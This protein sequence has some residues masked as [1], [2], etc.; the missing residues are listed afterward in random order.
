MATLL[1]DRRIYPGCANGWKSNKGKDI[2]DPESDIFKMEDASNGNVIVTNTGREKF[3][4]AL[5]SSTKM[6]LPKDSAGKLLQYVT[7][8]VRFKYPY[9]V[10]KNL[11]RHELDHKVCYK[12]RPPKPPGSNENPKIRNVSNFSTQWNRD[13]GQ[14]QIDLD[15]PGWVDSGYVVEDIAPEVWHDYWAACWYGIDDA[16]PRFSV[17]ALKLDNND[18][19]LI[20][21]EKQNVAQTLTNWELCSKGQIQNEFYEPGCTTIQYARFDFLWSDVPLDFFLIAA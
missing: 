9:E 18:P 15:P 10:Y 3:C 21:P 2:N 5:V 14:F 13:T 20:P 11:A 12:T 7:M 8:H 1:L 16:D 17:L 19:Y 6:E 4:G